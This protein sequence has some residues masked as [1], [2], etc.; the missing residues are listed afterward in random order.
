MRKSNSLSYSKVFIILWIMRTLRLPITTAN[1]NYICIVDVF[2]PWTSAT[3]GPLYAGLEPN[4]NILGKNRGEHIKTFSNQGR[5]GGQGLKTLEAQKEKEWFINI[6]YS[7]IKK[8][9]RTFIRKKV[10]LIIQTSAKKLA[11]HAAKKIRWAIR[12]TKTWRP[13]G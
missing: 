7:F 1:V 8:I 10:W 4:G 9:L 11:L 5:S 3:W 12:L 6:I 13:V 2:A